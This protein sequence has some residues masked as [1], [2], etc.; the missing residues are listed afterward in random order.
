[1]ADDDDDNWYDGFAAMREEGR[2]KK[3]SNLAQSTTLLQEH[4][5][6]FT[7]HNNGVHIVIERATETI[8][9]WPSTGLWWVRKSRNKRRGI[10]NLLKYLKGSNAT[11]NPQ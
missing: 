4:G 3:R 2:K 9:F 7:V 1:M 6:P 11:L 10:F 8:D 5:V